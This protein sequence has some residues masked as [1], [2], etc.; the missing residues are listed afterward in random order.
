MKMD[1]LEQVKGLEA[2]RA[3]KVAQMQAIADKAT[4]E[5]RS[6]DEAEAEEFDTLDGETKTI[7]GDLLR[8]KRL[9]TLSAQATPVQGNNAANAAQSR[10]GGEGQPP[11][12][13]TIHIAPRDKEEKFQGQNFTR[14]VIAKALSRLEGKPASMIAENRWGKTNPTLVEIVKANEVSGGGAESGEWGA[15]LALSDTKYTGDF[16][17]FLYAATA[18][19]KLPLR[20]VPANVFIKGQDGA[21]TGY[22]VG[23]GKAIPA[24]KA[25]FSD[26][27][28]R[29][30]EVGALA[31]V[32]NRLLRASEPSAEMLVRDALVQAS[33]Q[34]VDTTFFSAAAVSSGVS[35][36]G[37]LNGVSGLASTG[38]D[39]A[40]LLKDIENLYRPFIQAFNSSGL[41]FVSNPALAK[42]IG[43]LQNALGQFQFPGIGTMGGTLAGDPYVTGDNVHGDWLILL[44]PSDIYR[45][46]DSGVQV[47][48]SGDAMIEESSAPTGNT[49]TPTAATQVFN[50]MFQTNSTAIKVVRQVNFAKRRTSAVAFVTDADYGAADSP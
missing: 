31:V 1:L 43:L 23:Q 37:I 48:I 39:G 5:G 14:I 19:D 20:Q 32:T 22:W 34:R 24:S 21:A 6:M 10:S 12:G 45:I 46:G 42:S 30:L 33:A 38:T 35:P 3:A 49:L 40:A 16:I 13:P 2:T 47:S 8:M 17:T 11:R 9:Q 18:F 28:L 50:S 25:D 41:M 26:V 7:D 4:A 15:E 36:A 29:E 44:K 27:E